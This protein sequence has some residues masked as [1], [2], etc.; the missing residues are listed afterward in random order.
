MFLLLSV[1]GNVG[2]NMCFAFGFCH[3]PANQF[4]FQYETVFFVL[5]LIFF[6]P[7]LDHIKQNKPS[8]LHRILFIFSFQTVVRKVKKKSSEKKIDLTY[9]PYFKLNKK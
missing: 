6:G 5:F 1:Y 4:D 9:L 7:S 8:N 3:E 2:E